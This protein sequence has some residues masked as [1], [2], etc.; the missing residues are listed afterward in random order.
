L[1]SRIEGSRRCPEIVGRDS[2]KV[3]RNP[4]LIA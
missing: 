1:I 2:R 4:L 3:R